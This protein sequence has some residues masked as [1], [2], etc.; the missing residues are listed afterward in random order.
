MKNGTK[1]FSMKNMCSPTQYEFGICLALTS[2][3]PID[4][5]LHYFAKGCAIRKMPILSDEN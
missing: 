1:N 5:K 2:I 3:G 4:V